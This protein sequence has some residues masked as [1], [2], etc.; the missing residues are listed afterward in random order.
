MLRNVCAEGEGVCAK[1]I[2]APKVSDEPGRSQSRR[3]KAG[4]DD[5]G[6]YTADEM[7]EKER[8]S[9]LVLVD[10]EDGRQ[11]ALVVLLLKLASEEL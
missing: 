3:G 2:T 8:S 7:E 5:G 9:S 1:E 10:G 6:L 11:L 4:R